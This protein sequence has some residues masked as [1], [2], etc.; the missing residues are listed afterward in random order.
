[1]IYLLINYCSQTTINDK[2]TCDQSRV[3]N[4]ALVGKV[5]KNLLLYNKIYI[6]RYMYR[7]KR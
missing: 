5:R 3:P 4:V 6:Y 7:V 1:M 2:Y